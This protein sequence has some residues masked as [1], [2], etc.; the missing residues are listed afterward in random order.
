M[1][2]G[3]RSAHA[4]QPRRPDDDGA[5]RG[6]E[7]VEPSCRAGIQFRSKRPPLGQAQAEERSVM[8]LAKFL[9]HEP[10]SRFDRFWASPNALQNQPLGAELRSGLRMPALGLSPADIGALVER[11]FSSSI[12]TATS[13]FAESL[14]LLPSTPATKPLSMK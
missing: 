11:H 6:H 13:A 3:D 12:V 2:N 5:D 4:V 9:R 14:T 8:T 10:L 7:G 1:A